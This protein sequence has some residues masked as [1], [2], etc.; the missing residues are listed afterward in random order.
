MKNCKIVRKMLSEYID[1]VLPEGGTRTVKEH[2]EQCD[3]CREV[4]DSMKAIIASMNDMETV[5]PPADFLEKVNSRL[6]RRSSAA[7]FLRGIFLPL[8]F[9]LPLELAGLAAAVMLIVYVS[10]FL[11]KE[12]IEKMAPDGRI[13]GRTE[14][15]VVEAEAKRVEVRDSGVKNDPTK[16]EELPAEPEEL[17]VDDVVGATALKNGVV[18]KGGDLRVRGGRRGETQVGRVEDSPEDDGTVSNEVATLA[19]SLDRTDGVAKIEGKAAAGP[20]F[21]VNPPSDRFDSLLAV[22]EDPGEEL[23]AFVASI[24]GR[25]VSVPE[26]MILDASLKAA[27]S[28][29]RAIRP[30]TVVVPG[31][32]LRVFFDGLGRLEK[33]RPIDS[34]IVSQTSDSA[35]VRIDFR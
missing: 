12:G 14:E 6:E 19:Y 32:S 20:A 8:R 7:G 28:D 34:W 1:G 31:D 30:L 23:E 10:G 4:H 18:R 22:C 29:R 3:E 17:P 25:I 13:A 35:T 26:T 16:P 21:S 24:G 11:G 33:I 5:A 9:K 15:I 2:M 27:R